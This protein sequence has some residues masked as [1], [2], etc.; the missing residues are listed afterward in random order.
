MKS[1]TY[2]SRIL[3]K[4]QIHNVQGGLNMTGK[5]CDLFTQK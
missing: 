3:M 1:N 5:N 2:C 4:K